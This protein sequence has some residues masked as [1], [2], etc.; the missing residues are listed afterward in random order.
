MRLPLLVAVTVLSSAVSTAQDPFADIVG[1]ARRG[2][3]HAVHK[4]LERDP[5]AIRS[6]DDGGAT[7]LH[8]AAIR[9]HWRIVAELVAAGA[10]VSAVADDGE[11][12]LHG[13]C[14]HDRPDMAA[15][16][17]DAGA[18]PSTADHQGWTP[19]H[20]SARRGC[21]SVASLL[22]AR[23]ADPNAAGPEGWTPL[24]VARL[25]GWPEVAA[26]LEAG[27]ADPDRRDALGRRPADIATTR[28]AAAP[29][30]A[31]LLRDLVGLYDLG[32]D[33]PVKLWREGDGLGIRVRAP[34][35]LDHLEDEEF[36]CRAEPTRIRLLRSADG[37]VTGIEM[38][39]LRSTVTATRAPSRRYVGSAACRSC[40]QAFED[41]NP[42]ITWLRSRHGHAYWRLGSDWSLAL[43]H[44]RP[45][46]ADVEAPNSDARCLLCHV[47]ARQDDDALLAD[48]FRNEEG[49]GCE[50]CHGPGSEYADAEVM[51]NRDRFI[52]AGGRIPDAETCRSCHRNP[53]HFD[54]AT[55]WPKIAHGTPADGPAG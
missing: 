28:P 48:G 30:S 12:P 8:W 4:I 25:A 41:A 18:D 24:H 7:A 20:V 39:S 37:S 13:V 11:T 1:A 22:L 9:G 27:G 3:G 17:L 44:F 26:V 51:A 15:L 50:S 38:T 47:T 43:A 55:W 23:G 49:V 6:V 5:A 32:G 34:D 14:H 19:L 36:I 10:P 52:A 16:L 53:D 31:E 40:H 46:Y 2:D 54:Y 33:D 29:A 21:V 42:G 45:Q 35:R